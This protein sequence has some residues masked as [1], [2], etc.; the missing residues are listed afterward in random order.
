MFT[1]GHISSWQANDDVFY[2]LKKLKVGDTVTIT[3]MTTQHRVVATTIYPCN[4]VSMGEVLSL[5][6][7]RQPGIS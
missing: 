4:K 1:Y 2:N 3:M 7:T 6:A 5:V